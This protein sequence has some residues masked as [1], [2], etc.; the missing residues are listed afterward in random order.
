MI[1]VV[2]EP[3]RQRTGHRRATALYGMCALLLSALTGCASNPVDLQTADVLQKVGRDPQRLLIVDCLL[4]GQVRQLGARLT[5]LT[6]RRPI[7]ASAA[8]CEVRGGEYVAYDRASFSTS[9]KIWLP[10]AKEGDAEAQTYVG[11][12]YE[13]GLGIEADYA[14]AATWYRKAAEQN[15]S[16]AQINLGYLLES[17]LGVARDLTQAMNW[18]RKASGIS[19]GELEY[20]SSAENAR[21]IQAKAELGDLRDSVQ[22]LQA[23][24]SQKRSQLST[25][26]GSVE[27][28][29]AEVA[30]QR[31]AAIAVAAE[32]QTLQA[33]ALS[34][35]GRTLARIDRLESQLSTARGEQS[36]LTEKLR[37]QQ[38]L[39]L[40]AKRKYVAANR[41][42]IEKQQSQ[43]RLT[44]EL[45]ST[46]ARL[47]SVSSSGGDSAEA[48]QLQ[49][50]VAKMTILLA[51]QKKEIETIRS[52]RSE[53]AASIQS[54]VQQAEKN[55]LA[56]KR[57]LDSRNAAVLSLRSQL[58]S[59][60]QRYQG[61]IAALQTR[62]TAAD[63]E[64]KRLNKQLMSSQLSLAE[65][66]RQRARL[67]T[68]LSLQSRA[69]EVAAAEQLRLSRQLA[70]S[71]V[72][73]SLTSEEKFRLIE[74]LSQSESALA[75]SQQEQQRLQDKLLDLELAF[76]QSAQDANTS[77]ARLENVI[78]E[79]EQT[80]E[81]QQI[82]IV[83]LQEVIASARNALA[84]TVAPEEIA[85]LES[86]LFQR[87]EALSYA[88]QEQRRLSGKLMDVQ[89]ANAASDRE[90]AQK[91][92]A[93]EAKLVA[94]EQRLA[95]QQT[96]F[97]KLE[98]RV[99]QAESQVSKTDADKVATVVAI[100]PSIEIIE[101]PQR[102]TRGAPSLPWQSRNQTMDII[103]KVAPAADVLS[104][105]IN[106]VQQQLNNAGVFTYQHNRSDGSKLNIIAVTQTGDRE[107]VDFEFAV[108]AASNSIQA[109]SPKRA[110][111]LAPSSLPGV[112]FGNY[113]ALIVG[114]NNYPQLTDLITAENDARA[115]DQVLRS[116]YGF[117]TRL[118]LNADKNTLLT[119]LN[120]FRETLT[121]KDNL[122]IYY[123]G[124]GELDQNSKRG[125]WL[126]VDASP[127]ENSN[128][129]SNKSITDTIDAMKAKH[130]LV[131]ADSCYSG[132]LTRTAV[133]RREQQLTA[134]LT[135]RWYKVVSNSRVRVVLSSGGVKPV[136]DSVGD[137][138]HSLFARAFIDELS[139]N[140]GILEAYDLYTNVQRKVSAVARA[141]NIQQNPQYA[142]I[143]HAGHEAGEFFFLPGKQVAL[144]PREDGKAAGTTMVAALDRRL[145]P[146][147]NTQ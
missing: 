126:P 99:T 100:G 121:S 138:S 147:A 89:L 93:L 124:H 68:E 36:R 57:E 140:Q 49:A 21:R 43:Q 60:Q 78:N 11:E 112:N 92:A 145:L 103:G 129:V 48:Q 104:L 63:S 12:I 65:L 34:I 70:Q 118:L 33:Q 135:T 82:E 4:P 125:Y 44:S 107:Q 95:R 62:L 98:G 59:Q 110:G 144:H 9:L 143:K 64:Q 94:S 24:L 52:S 133:P 1:Q 130:V 83:R 85:V 114:N 35:P 87:E 128:W 117:K 58:G 73:S 42:L 2:A 17:G 111:R 38:L 105:K 120:A 134:D 56:L 27:A 122:I 139:A 123:A 67:D 90:S 51:Q 80:V 47:T 96:E 137:S 22:R 91:L 132:T 76:A 29:R 131:V 97:E 106:G 142:P 66:Q 53:Q 75:T 10:K 16:R 46:R 127:A 146:P 69:Y 37:D 79:R 102:V 3:T 113:Y 74:K 101:P 50:D 5:Y 32:N 108:P 6:P 40:D 61:D 72:T 13:K 8:D 18:Y 71:Q 19:D 77:A 136:Y 25:Q 86:Q 119:E 55:E 14:V 141:N 31:Q 116:R 23:E 15:Y 28:L 26:R 81:R 30:R 39:T 7:K 54:Q 84:L 41:E 45:A 109:V 115:V 20:V 88:Q